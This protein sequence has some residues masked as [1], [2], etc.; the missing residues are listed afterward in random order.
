M[1]LHEHETQLTVLIEAARREYERWLGLIAAQTNT[2][3]M[4]DACHGGAIGLPSVHDS[5]SRSLRPGLE[6]SHVAAPGASKYSRWSEPPVPVHTGTV[7]PS[8]T[9]PRR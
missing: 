6:R 9:L 3:G 7:Q 1:E 5:P 4:L 8:P 2:T